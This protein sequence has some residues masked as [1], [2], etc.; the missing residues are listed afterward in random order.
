MSRRGFSI[1]L[2][3]L[4]VAAGCGSD[5]DSTP[6]DT[7]AG[8]A[9]T[10]TPDGDGS[11]ADE[12]GGNDPTEA[13]DELV[14]DLEQTQA[15]QGGGGARLVVGDQEWV[16]DSVLCAFGAEEIGQEGA[17]VVVSSIQDGL[18]LYASIDAFGHLV[19]LD[20][21][22]NF[23]DPSV[24]LSADRFNNELTGNPTEFIVVDGKKV[25]ADTFF[26]DS[27][28]DP[29]TEPTAGSLEATCP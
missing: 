27:S 23:E 9:S 7:T 18:Q 26:A 13:V 28:A 21:I 20:D 4:I 10:A 29:G 11:E 15:T 2:F 1:I 5:S 16:F 3:V 19:S 22:D 6:T 24:S 17:E 12:D 14:D 25:T 8:T